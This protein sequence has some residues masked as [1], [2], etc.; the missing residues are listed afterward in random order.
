MRIWVL[1]ALIGALA[2]LVTP[3]LFHVLEQMTEFFAAQALEGAFSVGPVAYGFL[4]P[5][6]GAFVAFASVA[7]FRAY[8]SAD[9]FTYFFSDL[10]FQDGRRKLRYS[11]AHGL[12][13]LAMSVGG[14]VVGLEAFG[15]EFFSSLASWLGGRARLSASQVRTLMAS[16]AAAALAALLGQP[17]AAF[18]FVVELL[19]G[20]GSRSFQ[21]GIYAVTAFVAASVSATISRPGSALGVVTG[22]DHGLS[23]LFAGEVG[24]VDPFR[25][26]LAF[27][28][29]VPLSA[30]MAHLLV[31]SHRRTDAE[32]HN[33]FST[34]RSTDLSPV[35]VGLRL[36]FWAALTGV[37]QLKIPQVLEQGAVPLLEQTMEGATALRFAALALV[38]RVVMG[39][40]SYGALGTMGFVFPV[41]VTAG[42]AGAVLHALVE[43]WLA[44]GSATFVLIFTG[45]VF[46]AAMGTPVAATALVF[47][48]S[49]GAVSGNAGFLLLSLAANFSSHW[50]ASFV[51]KDRM[52][53]MG[54]YRHG[55]RFRNGMCFNTLSAI[56]VKDAMHTHVHPVPRS[57]SLGEAYRTLMDSRYLKLPV[58]DQAGKLQGMISL[59]D[60]FGLDTWRR[61]GDD[62]QVHSLVGVE[63][64]MRPAPVVKSDMSLES[65]LARMSDEEV[66]PVVDDQDFY[67][68]ILLRSDLENLYN[69]EVVKKAFRR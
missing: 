9:G 64:L 49:D 41:L 65:A 32:F 30:A 44:L 20:W 53:T 16:G 34:R 23:L 3:V 42:L 10:H 7:A 2:G 43:P 35:A 18:L 24:D 19:Y 4:L 26:L 15:V 48:W 31:A 1:A 56:N 57:A 47:G 37:V 69:K 5:L 40:V 8:R 27:L 6:G 68:G 22:P 45:S 58:V 60:F 59:S 66:T 38:L 11:L 62:S 33:L 12:G 13:A 21:V 52:P 46:S 36:G 29:V 28:V 54:L 50:I 17:L 55:I 63:E 51:V 67:Q 14:G 25:G 39:S 61:L